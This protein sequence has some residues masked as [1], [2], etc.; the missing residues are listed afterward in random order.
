VLARAAPR[1]RIARET[2]PPDRRQRQRGR[3]ARF[4]SGAPSAALRGGAAGGGAQVGGGGGR[5]CLA[6]RV[7]R[8]RRGGID[9]G[10]GRAAFAGQRAALARACGRSRGL[11]V[12]WRKAHRSAAHSSQ[13]FGGGGWRPS[14]HSGGGGAACDSGC[15]GGGG[16]GAAAGH[17]RGAAARERER[18][19]RQSNGSGQSCDEIA[20]S[21]TLSLLQR[22]GD[23]RRHRGRWHHAVRPR[24]RVRLRLRPRLRREQDGARADDGDLLAVTGTDAQREGGAGG[25]GARYRVDEAARTVLTRHVTASGWAPCSARRTESDKAV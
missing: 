21:L 5:A 1:P 2:R 3:E 23:G 20:A 22:H 8:P 13:R 11:T 12:G 15:G 17:N 6:R 16:D 4:D 24:R 7:G 9:A 10:D 19:A 25:R 18:E 14:G